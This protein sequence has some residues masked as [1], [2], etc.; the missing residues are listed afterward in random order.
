MTK[1]AQA[2]R[3]H[4]YQQ[5]ALMLSLQASPNAS[6]LFDSL[7]TSVPPEGAHRATPPSLE[8][9]T[10]LRYPTEHASLRLVLGLQLNL[11]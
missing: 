11:K 10:T 2:L 8:P 1:H 7:P 4:Y 5:N 6:R 9:S 3:H